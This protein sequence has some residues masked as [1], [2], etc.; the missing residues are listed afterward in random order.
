[1]NRDDVLRLAREAGFMTGVIHDRQGQPTYPLVQPI[2]HGCINE[3]ECIIK[4]AVAAEREA[5]AALAQEISD[6]HAPC[7][8]SGPAIVEAI[9]ARSTT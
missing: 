8:D 3:L 7:D 4:L 5:C 1:M 9:R 6:M 2:G